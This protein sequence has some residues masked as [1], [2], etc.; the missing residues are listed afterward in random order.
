MNAR[1][2]S[3]IM[4][5]PLLIG[6][7]TAVIVV[8]AVYLSYNANNGLPFTPTYD[9]KVMLPEASG[10]LRGNQVR[11]GGNRVG[12]VAS[13]SPVQNHATGRVTA[14]VEAK[15]EKSAG[16]L[17]VDSTA[18]VLSASA[19]GL[20]YLELEPG[21]S[22]RTI[23]S[24]GTIPVTQTREP[25]T[26]DNL[27]D[28]F[29]KPTRLANQ[30]NLVEFGRGFVGR[31]LGINEAVHEL[32]P[33]TIHARPVL[34][35][36]ASPQTGLRE[37]FIALDRAAKEV[38]PVATQQAVFYSDLDTFFTAWAGAANG[39]ER[40]IRGG[41]AALAQAIHSLPYE[42]PFVE[43]ATE[44]MRLLRPGAQALQ[45][46][47]PPLSHAFTVG[48]TNLRAATALNSSISTAARSLA[49]FSRN[50]IVNVALEDFTH[51]LRLGT[52]LVGSLAPMQSTC[53]YITLAFRN[54]ASLFSESVGVGTVA[55]AAVVLSPAGPNNEGFPSAV[56]ADG[57][58]VDRS[59]SVVGTTGA[60]VDD[61]HLHFNPYPNV[62]AP[63]Q[64]HECEAGN[65]SYTA[66][67]ATIGNVP[68]N[69]GTAH[70]AT[71]RSQNLFGVTYPAAQ[72]R[73]FPKEGKSK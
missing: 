71:K 2:R 59:A 57:P 41:P 67:R 20:K 17:P 48:A 11:I 54:I 47:A 31:G 58:S 37:F 65:E 38:A 61:N 66:G 1:R 23:P 70:E 21:K 73:D 45:T 52:P 30:R 56:P 26:I 32:V 40:T 55:R 60:L 8:V 50:P 46:A 44:F 19:V 43:K 25:V 3:S 7:V 29:D 14:E 49:Q 16:P 39:L 15:L 5:S 64:P 63:G 12:V 6:A 36:L 35:N 13:L 18:I 34:H 62:S 10:L 27:F 68:G 72:L 9:V 4:A 53:N 28:M 24:G 51:T 69:V 42:E 33:L 22:T